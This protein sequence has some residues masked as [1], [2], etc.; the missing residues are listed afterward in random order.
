MSSEASAYPTSYRADEAFAHQLDAV[1]PLARYRELFCLPTGADGK[2]LIYFA[3]HSLGLQPKATRALMEQEL[4]DWAKLG[5]AGHFKP[6]SPWYT[7]PELIREQAARLVG[8]K[9]SEVVLMNG[10][11]INLHLMMVSFYRPTAGRCKVLMD[12]PTFP[13][14]RYAVQTQLRFH[15]Y[16]PAECLITVQPR[17]RE[18]TIRQEDIESLLHER[19]KEIALVLLSGVNFLT[20]QRFDLQGLTAAA[21]EQGCVVGF[22]LAHSVGNVIVQ[23]HDWNVDFAVW[24]TYKYL[25]C[26][27]GAV[28]GCFV[29]EMHGRDLTLP[30]FAG[31]WGNDPATRFRMQEE[32][33]FVPQPGADGWQVSNPP[34][35]AMVPLRASFALFDE[36]GMP[37]LR[38]KSECLTGYLEYLLKKISAGPFQIITPP[39]PAERGNQLSIKVHNRPRELLEALHERG[40]VA[41][42]RE[43][44]II[45]VAPAP[46]NNTFHEVFRFSRILQEQAS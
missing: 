24:C 6:A 13:S 18:H 26:G 33:R 23:L 44:D 46:L 34:I 43:P 31:W 22:D 42:L 5:V 25:N 17:C 15:G 16:D 3:S 29:H 12:E 27:P 32:R 21:K 37:R 41:D 38:A 45:R 10:L 8:A 11:T 14:D 9:P 40:V 30:R 1:D 20:G 39:R 36:V 7:Y 2:P 28:A 19:G 4:D 35:F